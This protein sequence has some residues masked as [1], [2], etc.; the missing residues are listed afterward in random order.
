MAL[1]MGHIHRIL[2]RYVRFREGHW[3]TPPFYPI[4]GIPIWD[5]FA[6]E[7]WNGIPQATK[8]ATKIMKIVWLVPYLPSHP[9]LSTSIVG[10]EEPTPISI[11]ILARCVATTKHQFFPDMISFPIKIAIL[12]VYHIY[13]IFR[14]IYLLWFV[15]LTPHVDWVFSPVLSISGRISEWGG[16]VQGLGRETS[17]SWMGFTHELWKFNGDITTMKVTSITIEVATMMVLQDFSY[18]RYR[19]ITYNIWSNTNE[20]F[21]FFK[22]IW[23]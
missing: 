21:L 17:G 18:Q 4:L 2:H 1:Y 19:D 20:S 23:G 6:V 12:L 9:V 8:V 13:P 15:G 7:I 5:T 16:A 22:Y 3:R 14:A 11:P 10:G